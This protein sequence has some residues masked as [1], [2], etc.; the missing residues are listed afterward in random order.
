M[1]PFLELN[2]GQTHSFADFLKAHA[3]VAE[4]W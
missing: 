1:W 3:A 2:D 4:V